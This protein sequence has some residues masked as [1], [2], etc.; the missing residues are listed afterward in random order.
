MQ[1]LRMEE[2]LLDLCIAA[3]DIDLAIN[4]QIR[5]MRDEGY[6]LRALA[7]LAGVSHQTISNICREETR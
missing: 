2:K 7:E 3:T 4:A 5:E 1:D 6:S